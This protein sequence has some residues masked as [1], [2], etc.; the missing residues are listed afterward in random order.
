MFSKNS[1]LKHFFLFIQEIHNVQ[2]IIII[3]LSNIIKGEMCFILYI[4][5]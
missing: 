5:K 4:K 2:K 3:F 1:I